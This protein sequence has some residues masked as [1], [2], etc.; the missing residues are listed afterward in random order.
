MGQSL[1]QQIGVTVRAVR[2][3]QQL[4]QKTVAKQ[5]G[6]FLGTLKKIEKGQHS[7]HTSTIER[8][9]RGLNTTPE[10]L[11]LECLGANQRLAQPLLSIH[12]PK[13]PGTEPV[14][15]A[16]IQRHVHDFLQLVNLN[17]TKP[18]LAR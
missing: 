10:A 5:A 2:T 11:L 1:A 17:P 13:P 7:L 8:L 6:M 18:P 14:N 9:A 4:T 15:A 3:R 16:Y 12:I